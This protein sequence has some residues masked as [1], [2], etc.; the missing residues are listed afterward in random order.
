MDTIEPMSAPSLF[1]M[2]AEL[3]DGE[4][5]LEQF[6]DWLKHYGYLSETATDIAVPRWQENPRPARSLFTQFFFKE[7]PT[8]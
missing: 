3:P 1:A 7:Q 6:Q 4:S 5:I 2:L 8:N